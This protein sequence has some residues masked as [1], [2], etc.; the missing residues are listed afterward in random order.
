LAKILFLQGCGILFWEFYFLVS[1]GSLMSCN[2]IFKCGKDSL[3]FQ[4][5]FHIRIPYSLWLHKEQNKL[6]ISTTTQ[7]LPNLARSGGKI[8][9]VKKVRKG[10][11]NCVGKPK[12]QPN[13]YAIEGKVRSVFSLTS[14]WFYL[15]AK[16]V[17]RYNLVIQPARSDLDYGLKFVPSSLTLLTVTPNPT[18]GSSWNFTRRFQRYWSML[19]F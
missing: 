1:Q 3:M 10:D 12:Q 17:I 19:W 4:N 8:R 16:R 2:I 15:C 9:E 13:F 6:E 14:Q 7:K 18:V 11:R 5:P